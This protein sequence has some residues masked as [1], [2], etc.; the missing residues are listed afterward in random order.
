[1]VKATGWRTLFDGSDLDKW[2]FC[3][4]DVELARDAF[5]IAKGEVRTKTG[6]L[7]WANYALRADIMITPKGRNPKYCV[8]LTANGT[9]V[10]CQLVPHCML[11]AYYCEKPSKNPKGFTHLIA[12]AEVRVPENSWFTFTMRA[13]HGRI[14]GMVDGAEIANAR[15]PAGTKGMPGFLINQLKH[16]VVKIRNIKIRLLRPTNKQLEEFHKHPLYNW[17]RYV[18][19]TKRR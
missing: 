1:M 2:S 19:S 6:G 14:T 16:C 5:A 3:V 15:I 17:L 10:Y 13:S 7:P 4:G 11:I 8:Q 9:C 18:E 12:P